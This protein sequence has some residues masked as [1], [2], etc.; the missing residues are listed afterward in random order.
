MTQTKAGPIEINPSINNQG[1]ISFESGTINYKNVMDIAS[2][3]WYN[4]NVF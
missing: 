4:F 2:S 3:A 1:F